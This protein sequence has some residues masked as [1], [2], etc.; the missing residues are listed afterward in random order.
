M[1][2][3]SILLASILCSGF[4]S[5]A[6]ERKLT[7]ENTTIKF[8]GSKK[9]GKHEG[10]FKQLDGRLVVDKAEPARS[11][12]AVTI[13]IASMTTDAEKLTAHLKSPDF[14]DAKRYPQA[15]FV[16]K[17][18]KAGGEKDTYTV[19]GDLTMRGRTHPVTFPARA[20]TADGSTTVS[21]Q[22]EIKRTDWGMTYGMDRVND[23]VQLTLEVKLPTESK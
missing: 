23:A 14:F 3:P 15:K 18:I 12:L 4:S 21:A 20:V 17:S 19:A 1:K 7:A 16:S 9:D 13:D 8:V 10:T 11:N 5:G 2:I 22:L 6:E